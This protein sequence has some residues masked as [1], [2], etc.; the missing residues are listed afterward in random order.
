MTEPTPDEIARAARRQD[1]ADRF[2]QQFEE[3]RTLVCTV[4]GPGW[5]PVG[6]H[7]LVEKEEE[8]RVRKEGGSARAFAAVYTAERN[9]RRRHVL[10][11]GD[12][13]REVDGWEHGFGDMLTEPHPTQGFTH[14]GQW[15]RTHRFSL[16]WSGF[17]D[18]Y[19][20]RTAVQ[21]A[22]DRV[23][24]EDKAAAK[25]AAENPLYSEMI[26]EEHRKSRER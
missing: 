24:R 3:A 2:R 10:V 14:Q 18:S 17:E 13:K 19:K 1:I 15:V 7:A 26:L 16:H 23:K 22:R 11:I 12:E 21:L 5:R 6:K 8:E 25:E 20:P 9:G 4:L